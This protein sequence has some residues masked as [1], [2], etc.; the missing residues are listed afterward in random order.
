VLKIGNKTYYKTSNH[1]FEVTYNGLKNIRFT[2]VPYYSSIEVKKLS[3]KKG[4][5]ELSISFTPSGRTLN[6]DFFI[7]FHIHFMQPKDQFNS[8][9]NTSLSLR[10]LSLIKRVFKDLVDA[11][12]VTE[13]T[14]KIHPKNN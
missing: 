1:V 9:T 8:T 12:T 10:Q 6:E 4:S 11:G 7:H 5:H 3:K 2:E 13:G 14:E